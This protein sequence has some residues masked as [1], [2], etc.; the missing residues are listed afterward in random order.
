MAS[1]EKADPKAVIK[2]LADAG[3][4]GTDMELA[5][6][7]RARAAAQ[8]F[9]HIARRDL[10]HAVERKVPKARLETLKKRL[11]SAEG[12]LAPAE[13]RAE[14]ALHRS[15]AGAPLFGGA[16]P[17][18]G[19]VVDAKGAGVRGAAVTLS[20][21]DDKPLARAKSDASG[22]FRL[23]A[24]PGGTGDLRLWIGGSAEG[25]LWET[26]VSRAPRALSSTFHIATIDR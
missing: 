12:S 20:G 17:I 26:H 4:Q 16:P 15:K 3:R 25:P 24:P 23:A 6:A 2:G 7:E 14:Q 10:Q 8:L 5:L 19:R 13:A 11:R 9:S 21:D 1:F 22:Y 18:V